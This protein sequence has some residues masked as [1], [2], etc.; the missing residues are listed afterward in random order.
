[1]L[2]IG[3]PVVLLHLIGGIHNDAMMMALLL[4][5]LGLFV[6]TLVVRFLLRKERDEDDA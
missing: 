2:A 5:G 6:A 4:T 3:N 1:V